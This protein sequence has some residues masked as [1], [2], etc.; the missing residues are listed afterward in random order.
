M[1]LLDELVPMMIG[2][3]DDQLRKIKNFI[4]MKLSIKD[5][6]DT[7]E[8]AVSSCTHCQS[9]HSI[10]YGIKNGKQRFFARLA[11]RSLYPQLTLSLLKAN[12]HLKHG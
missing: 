5:Q 4:L 9:I 7:Q 6:T 12:I 2:M 1:I 3:S 8:T 11:K 10:K